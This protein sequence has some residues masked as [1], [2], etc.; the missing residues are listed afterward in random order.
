MMK[1]LN[2]YPSILP[3]YEEF[4][5][6]IFA[7]F[8]CDL[9]IINNKIVFY[10]VVNN[11][12]CFYPKPVIEEYNIKREDFQITIHTFFVTIKS[13]FSKLP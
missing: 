10:V 8:L 3:S 11:I 1:H 12:K 2:T 4:F 6:P 9:A 7:L 13:K 5:C